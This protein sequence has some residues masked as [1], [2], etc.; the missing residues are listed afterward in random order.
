MRED[1]VQEISPSNV[2][3]LKRFVTLERRLLSQY[4][5]VR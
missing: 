4:P 1:W 3:A 5:C 2:L